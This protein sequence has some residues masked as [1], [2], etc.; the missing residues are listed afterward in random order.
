M[1]DQIARQQQALDKIRSDYTNA[2]TEGQRQAIAR[3][4]K[5]AKTRLETLMK[6]EIPWS[7]TVKNA[8][9]IFE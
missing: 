7:D 4:G 9:E 8:E 6:N 3:V 5:V 2:T 1:T